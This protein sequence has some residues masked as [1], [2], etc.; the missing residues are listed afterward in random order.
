MT[1]TQAAKARPPKVERAAETLQKLLG[2][3]TDKLSKMS[4]MA[5]TDV[6]R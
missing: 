1:R 5:V 3:V 4:K 2:A 6:S